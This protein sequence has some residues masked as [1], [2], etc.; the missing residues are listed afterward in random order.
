MFR[1]LYY[2]SLDAHM[3]EH[4]STI[5]SAFVLQ[6][7]GDRLLQRHR[8]PLH[9]T[10]PQVD[11]ATRARDSQVAL[12]FTLMESIHFS[13]TRSMIRSAALKS[14]AALSGAPVA[15]VTEGEFARG[16]P[17]KYRPDGF[18]CHPGHHLSNQG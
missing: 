7:V 12:K 10:R 6:R 2:P 16:P 11:E 13:C 9:L 3:V 15:P 17:H 4:A 18:P 14:R 8:S 1:P 5:C